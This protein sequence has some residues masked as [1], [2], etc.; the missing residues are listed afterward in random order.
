MHYFLKFIAGGLLF[1]AV[2]EGYYSLCL[3]QPA[4]VFLN[5]LGILFVVVSIMCAIG[6]VFDK[7]FRQSVLSDVACYFLFGF[8][9]L[10]HEWHVQ[11]NVMAQHGGGDQLTMFVAWTSYYLVPR[12][13]L[14]SRPE[15]AEL[16]K[17]IKIWLAV[18][19]PVGMVMAI[20][21]ISL[22]L[23]GQSPV[24]MGALTPE[25]MKML[26]IWP[27]ISLSVLHI[28]F[29]AYFWVRH[30]GHSLTELMARG[31]SNLQTS[32]KNPST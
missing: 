24:T 19:L 30:K 5:S 13:L 26:L 9:G 4:N 25:Q 3:H 28:T 16:A 2:T 1:G 14:D 8:A 18:A 31:S 20:I 32:G 12:I 21:I 7:I 22:I 17:A 27:T 10:A 15:I 29:W 11:G 6:L 23:P